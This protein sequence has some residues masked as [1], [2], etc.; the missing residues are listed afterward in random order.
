MSMH[1]RLAVK[2]TKLPKKVL[3]EDLSE[4]AV[5]GVVEPHFDLPEGFDCRGY[6]PFG[7]S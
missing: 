5:A 7:P 6:G 2:L 3:F 4:R 1:A